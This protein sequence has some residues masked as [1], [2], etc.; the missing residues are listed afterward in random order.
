MKQEIDELEK[1]KV[2]GE[3]F[4]SETGIQRRKISKR[5]K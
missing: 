4:K 5:K 3:L 1:A 2:Y